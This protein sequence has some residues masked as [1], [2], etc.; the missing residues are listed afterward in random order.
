VLFRSEA[1][2]AVASIPNAFGGNSTLTE[3]A[4]LARGLAVKAGLPL[5]EFHSSPS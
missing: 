4:Q 5:V 1:S 3:C 2:A